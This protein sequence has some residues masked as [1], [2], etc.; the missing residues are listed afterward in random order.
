MSL[1]L[2]NC[3]V[4]GINW[5]TFYL[6]L[7]QRARM[8][9]AHIT[10]LAMNGNLLPVRLYTPSSCSVVRR[11]GYFSLMTE[12]ATK[13]IIRLVLYG[14]IV[15]PLTLTEE[16]GLRVFEKRLPRKMFERKVKAATRRRRYYVMRS[17]L[18]IAILY[19]TI[20]MIK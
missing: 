10:M 7:I 20:W 18:F 4:Y 19:N 5:G 3:R 14:R 9:E 16:R 6:F 2:E 15:W 1:I 13:A 17:S 12:L 8:R 11:G